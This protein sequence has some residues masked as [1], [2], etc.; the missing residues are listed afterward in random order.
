MYDYMK[1]LMPI[2]WKWKNFHE[3]LFYIALFERLKNEI[4]KEPFFKEKKHW[5]KSHCKYG[6]IAWIGPPANSVDT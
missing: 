2:A 4:E 1:S 3:K 5:V 6:G